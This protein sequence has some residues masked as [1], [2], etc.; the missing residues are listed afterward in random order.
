M[1]L[2]E[3]TK[4]AGGRERRKRVGRGESSGMGRTCGRGNKGA[5]SR[6]GYKRKRLYES[7]QSRL[8]SRFPKRGFNNFNF[9]TEYVPVNLADL[10]GSFDDGARI[11]ISAL[12]ELRLVQGLDP[13]VKVL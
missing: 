2:H 4:A 7:G 1:M 10:E 5:Q 12:Q 13:T 6:A 3:I 8:F 9:R 11:D